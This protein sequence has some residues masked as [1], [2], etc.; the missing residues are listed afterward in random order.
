MKGEE[1]TLQKSRRKLAREGRWAQEKGKT[2]FQAL[3]D[4]HFIIKGSSA[5]TL[6]ERE[7]GEE[8]S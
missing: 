5:L 3:Q 8:K 7:G 2:P 1:R 6:N 4:L